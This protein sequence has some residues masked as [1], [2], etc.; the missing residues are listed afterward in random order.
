MPNFAIH[1]PAEG[2]TRGFR[3]DLQENALYTDLGG[4]IAD[5][6]R[7]TDPNMDELTG[8]LKIMQSGDGA[9][10]ALLDGH[11]TSI[12]P[13][14]EIYWDATFEHREAYRLCEEEDIS[15][16]AAFDRV[17]GAMPPE[18]SAPEL[19]AHVMGEPQRAAPSAQEPLP[20]AVKPVADPMVG[21]VISGQRMLLKL[22]LVMLEDRVEEGS[23]DE[24]Q[25]AFIKE[26]LEALDGYEIEI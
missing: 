19:S 20:P 6:R 5:P 10:Q 21:I 23:R 16:E 17:H 7:A 11:P 12:E 24:K 8:D 18:V 26:E 3:Y 13:V 9:L 15:L 25:L 22:A 2:R 1:I 4:V 14:Y